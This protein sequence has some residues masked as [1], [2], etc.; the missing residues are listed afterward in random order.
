MS[1]PDFVYEPTSH[2][3]QIMAN[4]DKLSHAL[5]NLVYNA[6]DF[7]PSDGKITLS[8]KKERF[9]QRFYTTR[10]GEGGQ[11]LGLAITQTIITEHGGTI[12]A[13]PVEGKVTTFTIRLPLVHS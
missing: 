11:G 1:G 8:L 7:T 12:H 9:F 5:E 4:S 13:D 6:S 2:P 10:S 3:C